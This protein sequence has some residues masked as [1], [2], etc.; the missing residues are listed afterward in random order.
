MFSNVFKNA[1]LD[2]FSN[3]NYY[4]GKFDYSQGLRILDEGKVSFGALYEKLLFEA[5]NFG[6]INLE[7]QRTT[8]STYL[9]F[10]AK[11]NKFDFILGSRAEKYEI[12]GKTTTAD[13]IPFDQ[14]RWFPNATVQYNISPQIFLNMNYNKK[15][16][17]RK[18]LRYNN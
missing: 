2:N 18:I 16:M 8:A 14:F 7:Y 12:N 1:V 17:N 3:Q 9:E 11:Y 10:Q 4:N 6:S 13:L 5:K 15:V